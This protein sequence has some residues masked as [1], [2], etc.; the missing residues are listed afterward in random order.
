LVFSLSSIKIY[1]NTCRLKGKGE[2]GAPSGD[3]GQG[4][5]ERKNLYPLPFNLFPKPNSELKMHKASSIEM[6]P[7][8]HK[9]AKVLFALLSILYSP[10][11]NTAI[12][13]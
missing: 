11:S 9:S 13:N 12:G 10:A 5:G 8:F 4:K 3:K 2:G 7:F 6:Y 1:P